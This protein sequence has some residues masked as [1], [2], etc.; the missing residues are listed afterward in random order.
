MSRRGRSFKCW[1]GNYDGTR[2]ALVIAASQRVAARILSCG[3]PTLKDYYTV[4]P[5]PSGLEPETLYTRPM[6]G[7][8]YVVVGWTK[9]LCALTKVPKT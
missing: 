4:C 6:W 1:I 9:G 3:V 8:G 7:A 2:E 5:V